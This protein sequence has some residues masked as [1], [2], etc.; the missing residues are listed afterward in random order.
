[1]SGSWRRHPPFWTAPKRRGYKRCVNLSDIG[2]WRSLGVVAGLGLLLALEWALP[3]R[4]PRQPKLRHAASNLAIAGSNAVLIAM[5]F[6]GLLLVWA[7]EVEARQWGLLHQ[8]G[9]GWLPSLLA[10][11]LLLDL[12]FYGLHWANHRLPLLWRFHR[13]H[14][15]DLDLD[16]TSALRFHFGEMLV[17]TGVKAAVIPVL[18]VSWL[19]LVVFEIIL[20]AAAQFQHSNLRLPGPWDERLRRLIV[21]PHMHWSHHSRFPEDH[22][23]NFGT[24][25]SFW[26]RLWST[27]GIR[28]PQ[29]EI[30]IGLDDYPSPRE[31]GF[32][33]FFAMPLGRGCRLGRSGMADS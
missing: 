19:G 17:S 18:G 28:T 31:A 9:L 32:T 7:R 23:R 21:T 14:H 30:Q 26:D 10:A 8:A 16:V 2:Q 11:V 13:A 12:V 29:E 22:N 25:F 6:G 15:S 3:S 24:I 20:V 1:M 4:A 33:R 5:L 27:Y